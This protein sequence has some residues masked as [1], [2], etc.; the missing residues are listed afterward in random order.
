MTRLLVALLCTLMLAT[1]VAGEV[2]RVRPAAVA[3]SWYPGDKA[4]LTAYL[5]GLL[6][7]GRAD[8]RGQGPVI[9]LISPHAGYAY[10]GAVAADAYRQVRGRAFKRVLLLGPSHHG[11]FH[12]LSIADVTH[13]ETPLGRI[14]LDMDA[15][16]RLRT[17]GLVGA[18]PE[19]HRDEHSLEMQLPFLQRALQP[20]WQLVPILVG[21]LKPEDYPAAAD[22]LRPLLGDDTLLVVS[23]D[24]THYGPNYGYL[25][26]PHDGHTAARLDALDRG[27]L[28]FILDKDP[29]G[30]LDYRA[31]TGDTICGYRPIALL[32][33]LLP[34]D[35][36]GELVGH[37]TSGELTG[38]YENSVSYLGIAFRE[39][40]KPQPRPDPADETNLPP[41]D[42]HLL[43][44]LATAAVEVAAK[45]GDQEARQRL[46]QLE[47]DVP[48]ELKMPAGA[49]VTLRRADGELRGCVGYIKPRD[50]LYR[51]VVANG[52]NAAR[53]DWRFP[54]LQPQ[55]L[56]GLEV[57]VS[58]LTPPKPVDSYRDFK[59]G[60]EGV[61]LEKDGHSAVF[62]PEVAREYGWT[63]EQT[64]S[65]L[66]HK[67]GLADDAW[68]QGASFKTFRTQSFS[69]PFPAE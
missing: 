63:R 24:F 17:S 44:R 4:Q 46:A 28:A 45:P 7:K 51:A 50:P 48:A 36:Q 15:V 37:A 6:D 12:G 60:E 54:P 13:Y 25:P 69:A 3:G 49:F 53:N 55:E 10:S 66:A 62:L 22:L 38:D 8:D 1:A 23:S 42:M 40:V 16:E 47:E 19:A 21:Q 57:E 26:F 58:V 64:L 68:Q 14:P 56:K 67:A 9:A 33:Q 20:G 30:F 2:E 35:S 11:R 31:R 39:P 32:L 5:D 41:A 27:S 29:Q 52:I 61:I 34:P 43:H 65:H 59:V 18:D